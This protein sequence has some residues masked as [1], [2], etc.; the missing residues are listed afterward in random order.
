MTS[1]PVVSRAFARVPLPVAGEVGDVVRELCALALR[2]ADAL[3]FRTAVLAVLRREM[4][5]DAA[6]FHELSPRVPMSHAA[7]FGLDPSTVEQNSRGWDEIAVHLQPLIEVAAQQNGAATDLE[8]FPRGTRSRREWERRVARPFGITGMLI[9]HLQSRGR[10]VSGVVLM[11]RRKLFTR[12]ERLWLGQLLECLTLCDV[13]WQRQTHPEYAGLLLRPV[14]RDQRLTVRQ[15]EV[16]EGV[17]LGRTNRQIGDLLG[18]SANTVR[19][20]LAEVCERLGASNHADVV[21]LAVL[22]SA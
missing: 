8:A 15:R 3:A 18:I 12:G 4:G 22:S 5:F 20:T 9:G 16:V 6:I 21:R 1:R 2:A 10:V 17:A 7:L 11:R 13:Y 19:N 14:C